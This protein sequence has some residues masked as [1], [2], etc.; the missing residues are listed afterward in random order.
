MGQ[1]NGKK[2]SYFGSFRVMSATRAR[3]RI[4]VWKTFLVAQKAGA[5]LA[6][7]GLSTWKYMFSVQSLKS[8]NVELS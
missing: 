5:K 3:E 8:R 4:W 1:K 2:R 7:S 6:V